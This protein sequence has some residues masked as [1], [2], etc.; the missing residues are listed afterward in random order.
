M[1]L[2]PI[3]K[4]LL[5]YL[6]RERNKHGRRFIQLWSRQYRTAQALARR[7]LVE[8]SDGSARALAD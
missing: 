1:K 6:K 8:Y 2:T 7:N 3:Q 4:E 5:R